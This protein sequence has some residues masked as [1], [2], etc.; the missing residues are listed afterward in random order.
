MKVQRSFDS[1]KKINTVIILCG[2]YGTRAKII[3]SSVPKALIPIKGKPFIFWVLKNLSKFNLKK[4]FLCVGYKGK[5]IQRYIRSIKDKFNFKIIIS[6]EKENN[7]LGTGGAIKKISNKLEDVFFVMNGD[8]FLFL[9]LRKMIYLYYKNKKPILMVAYKNKDKNHKNNINIIKKNFF[10]NKKSKKKMN[11]IDYGILIIKKN[12]FKNKNKKFEISDLL[13]RESLN[14]NISFMLTKKRF[15][16]IGG[17]RGYK[18]T[19]KNFYK[20]KNEIY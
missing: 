2:G 4:V 20:I 17:L 9:D 19:L 8:T 11:Y 18:Q 16:E 15:F 13:N 3:N 1:K 12:F 6:K 10:Y 14:D 7:L 5:Q